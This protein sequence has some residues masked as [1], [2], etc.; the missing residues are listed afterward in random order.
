MSCHMAALFQQPVE[1]RPR[2]CFYTIAFRE[3]VL[4]SFSHMVVQYIL[5]KSIRKSAALQADS[6]ELFLGP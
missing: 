1:P 5:E 2:T 4:G 3:E 6:T